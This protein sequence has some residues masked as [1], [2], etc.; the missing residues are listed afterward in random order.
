[1]IRAVYLFSFVALLA[2]SFVLAPTEPV[3]HVFEA[4]SYSEIVPPMHVVRIDQVAASAGAFIELASGVGQ[5]WRGQG[6]GSVTYRL[7]LERTGDYTVWGR[8][9]WMDGCTNA[10]FLSVNHGPTTVFG[11]DPIFNQWHWVKSTRLK[12]ERGVNYLTFSNHSDGTALDKLVVTDDPF[13]VPEGLGSEITRFYDGFAGCDG[14][15]TGSWEFVSGRWRVVP[16]VGES[17]GG[18]NDVLAQWDEG[19]S[20]ALGGFEVWR[21]YDARTSFMVGSPGKVGLIFF[22]EDSD[23][24]WRVFLEIGE[25]G[26]RLDVQKCRTGI[27][28][29]LQSESVPPC[30]FDRWYELGF[31]IGEDR[32]KITLD[33]EL[34]ATTE[35]PRDRSGRIGLFSQGPRGV[36]FDNVEV[37]FRN[38]KSAPI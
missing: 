9:H 37:R 11:N 16:S 19:E 27:C 1:M 32:L 7:D 26:T 4:E 3:C 36:Y 38:A 29:T 30:Q 34:V 21:D 6:G 20:L 23:S 15:N 28:D 35:C 31:R 17:Q 12:L 25:D 33:G 24:E 13:Y 18:V 10:F 2:S 5:G 8:S 14:D 22:H